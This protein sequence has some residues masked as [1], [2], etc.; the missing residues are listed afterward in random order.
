MY[1]LQRRF[2]EWDKWD[3]LYGRYK[4]LC[5]ARETLEKRPDKTL[6]RIAE[7]Y[8]VTRYKAVKEDSQ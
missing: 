7:E 5:E 6:C 1:V 3:T 2:R 8:T 4:T